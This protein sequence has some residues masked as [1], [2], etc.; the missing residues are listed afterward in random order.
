MSD[1]NENHCTYRPMFFCFM[2]MK[3]VSDLIAQGDL[4][5]LKA[6]KKDRNHRKQKTIEDDP[7]ASRPVIARKIRE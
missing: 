3:T 6:K 7:K 2:E 5:S 1:T 4:E